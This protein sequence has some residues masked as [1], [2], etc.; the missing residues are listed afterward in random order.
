[1]SRALRVASGD[2]LRP[3]P[4]E[5]GRESPV[6]AA[7]GDQAPPCTHPAIKRVALPAVPGKRIDQSQRSAHNGRVHETW[8]V[9]FAAGALLGPA[10]VVT[11]RLICAA[12]SLGSICGGIAAVLGAAATTEVAVFVAVSGVALCLHRLVLRPYQRAII[13]W[14]T[15]YWAQS[16]NATA[17]EPT[18][19][20]AGQV[21][22]GGVR[23]QARSPGRTI[24]SGSRVKVSGLL[25]DTTLLVYAETRHLRH[26]ASHGEP[27]SR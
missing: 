25:N 5:P 23:W 16:N 15:L 24:P 9:W 13:N 3:L 27:A 7:I 4:T 8:F 21:R 18:D 14:E 1:V 10:E 12:L 6:L 19:R 11:R 22:Y 17:T 26:D 20:H 2:G